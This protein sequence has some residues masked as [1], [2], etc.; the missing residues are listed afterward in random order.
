MAVEN[1]VYKFT[2][3]YK[4]ISCISLYFEDF[5]KKNK[6]KKNLTTLFFNRNLWDNFSHIHKFN[7]NLTFLIISIRNKCE[8]IR[9]L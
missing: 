5:S 8:L 9:H 1:M 2:L 3:L 7:N 6:E 4:Y